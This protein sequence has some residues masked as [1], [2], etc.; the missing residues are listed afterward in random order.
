MNSLIENGLRVL[1]AGSL[2]AATTLATPSVV[3][4]HWGGQ[5]PHDHDPGERILSQSAQRHTHRAGPD[6]RHHEHHTVPA[7]DD[8]HEHVYVAFLGCTIPLPE[9]A[10]PDGS[11]QGPHPDRGLPFAVSFRNELPRSAGGSFPL[12]WWF[13]SVADNHL[14][15]D[16]VVEQEGPPC[17]V[18][19]A[20]FLCDRARHERSGVLLA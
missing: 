5:R 9:P 17:K 7:A 11:H 1:L 3:H 20:P 18:A 12:P 19:P 16:R 13:A 8:L 10:E 14:L 2:L 15:C 6:H 4:S